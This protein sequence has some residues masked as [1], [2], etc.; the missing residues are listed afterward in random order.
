MFHT[1]FSKRIKASRD[2]YKKRTQKND[3]SINILALI[4]IWTTDSVIYNR[5]ALLEAGSITGVSL[6]AVRFSGGLY[7]HFWSCTMHLFEWTW[8]DLCTKIMFEIG[9]LGIAKFRKYL[10]C[11][12]SI[13]I[14]RTIHA[15]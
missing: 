9:L 7:R 2:G 5:R 11:I 15:H 1:T 14:Y 13:I 3:R 4:P 8:L 12:R 10:E 6:I